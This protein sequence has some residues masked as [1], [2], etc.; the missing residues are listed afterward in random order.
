MDVHF[1]WWNGVVLCV[2]S[3]KNLTEKLEIFENK[4]H[5]KC[6]I[7][8]CLCHEV[9]S[10]RYFDPFCMIFI[11]KQT[12]CCFCIYLFALCVCKVPDHSVLYSN[13][14]VYTTIT[15]VLLSALNCY[16]VDQEHILF[17]F[18]T[19]VYLRLSSIYMYFPLC[20]IPSQ[21]SLSLS[22]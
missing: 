18:S 15:V 8:D 13:Q 22:F 12:G 9:P 16:W 17:S 19:T 3:S 6:S 5:K 20:K 14:F 11:C 2:W 7:Y 21:T 10:G 1:E 4:K